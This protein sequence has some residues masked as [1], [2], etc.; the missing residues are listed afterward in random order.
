MTKKLLSGVLAVTL[1]A[2]MGIHATRV[3]AAPASRLWSIAV[4]IE[5][6]DG[7]IYDNVFAS[8]VPT[9][10]LPAIL[11]ACNSSHRS[12]SAVRFHCYPI[13]E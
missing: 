1:T 12:G 3:S 4:H 7:F 5:Y 8:G 10:E 9:S 13:A 11:A 6:V 2:L